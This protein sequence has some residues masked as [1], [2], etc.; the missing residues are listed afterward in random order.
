VDLTGSRAVTVTWAEPATGGPV[1]SYTVTSVPDISAPARCTNV[2]VLTC[3]FDRL[4]PG[5]TY[6]FKVSANGTGDR[7]TASDAS[8]PVTIAAAAPGAPGAPDVEVLSSSSARVTWTAPTGGGPVVTYTAQAYTSG[9]PDAG[10][11]SNAGCTDVSTLSC[12][13]TG[14][15]DAET[16]TFRVTA[17]GPGGDSLGERSVPVSTAGPGKPAAPTVQLAGPN[18][19][20]VTWTAAPGAGAVTSYTVTST[21]DV[22]APARCTNVRPPVMTCVFDRLRG[23]TEYTF[24]VV[25]NGSADRATSSDASTPIVAGPPAAMAAPTVSPAG[26]NAVTVTWTTPTT[27]GPITSYLVRSDPSSA[28]CTVTGKATTSCVVSGLTSTTAYTFQVKAV[29]V[30]GG[31]DSEWSPASA[32]ITPG[33]PAA[34]T[35]VAVSGGDGQISVSW[36]TPA[37]TTGIVRYRAV[38]T[39]GNAYCETT[40]NTDTECV[41]TDVTNLRFYTVTVIAVGDGVSAV[42]APST[43]VRP[44]AGR[45]GSPTAVTATVSSGSQAVV[46]WTAPTSVGNGIARYTVTAVNA[47][48]RRVTCSTPNG[49]TTNCALTDLSAGTYSVTVVSV[50]RSAS[51][52]SEPSAA[53]SLVLKAPPGVPTNVTVTGTTAAKSL[54][55]D[56]KAGAAGDG[57]AGFTVTAT[58]ASGT[59]TAPTCTTLGAVAA[60][61]AATCNIANLTPGIYTV[62]VVA[63]GTTGVPNSAASAGVQATALAGLAPTPATSVPSG[64]PATLTVSSTTVKVGATI[65]VG[66]SGFAAYTT[67]NLVIM[68]GTS[69]GTVVTDASGAF[70]D[71][72]VTL[73]AGTGAKT[74]AA[75]GLPS[76]GTAFRYQTAALTVAAA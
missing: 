25:A 40:T 72:Q 58:P 41:I 60:G 38:A 63:R 74:L 17:R 8:T 5:T 29:G 9:T 2:K 23:G 18:A 32:P 12:D 66:G 16:Y 51:G 14:L 26:A 13:F 3:V 69:L 36:T 67:V 46:S 1:E 31:G 6:T 22:S 27:G 33:A 57:M 64:S 7:S 56:W 10:L 65:T 20:T 68:G 24:K 19:A 62:T 61:G 49:S 42:S 71:K 53:Y 70:T 39:P 47:A 11:T 59:G 34:P 30:A 54:R 43:P 48:G 4:I 37:V 45:P 21:P 76:T 52:Y 55:V 50:G 75:V 35:D 44:T 15:S 28:G 73:P